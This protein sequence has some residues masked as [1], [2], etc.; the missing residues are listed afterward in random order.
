MC[1]PAAVEKF[2]CCYYEV[3]VCR[4]LQWM[5]RFISLWWGCGC[6]LV[7]GG[8]EWLMLLWFAWLWWCNH[9]CFGCRIPGD[10]DFL[11]PCGLCAVSVN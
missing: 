5:C 2:P 4:I 8:V 3:V 7:R 11:A 9:L 10:V 6:P 1:D